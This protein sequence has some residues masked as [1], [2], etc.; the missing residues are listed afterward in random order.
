M[1]DPVADQE[2]CELNAFRRLSQRLKKEFPGAVW[3]GL[4]A[5]RLPPN[6]PPIGQL[7]F[8]CTS[9]AGAKDHQPDPCPS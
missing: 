9:T 7:H 8:G 3:E 6:L 4:R 1:Q 2:D 5:R